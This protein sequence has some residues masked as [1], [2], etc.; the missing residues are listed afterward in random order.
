VILATPNAC[1][2]CHTDKTATWARD[3]IKGW[4]PSPKPGAQDFAEAFDLGDRGAPGAQAALLRIAKTETGSA[5]ARASAI[6]RLGRYPSPEALALAAQSLKSDD[7]AVQSAAITVIAGADPATRKTLLVPLLHNTS[8]LV[9]MNAARALAEVP[10]QDLSADDR[11]ALERVLDEYVAA[12][13]FNAERP[14]SHA[15][16]GALYRERGKTSDAR[17]AFETALALD[18]TF[19]AAAIS[20]AD[21]VRAEGDETAAEKILRQ[22]LAASPDSGAIQHALGLSLIRQ[23]RTADAM[24]WLSKAAEAAPDDP[25]FSYVLAVAL[26]DTGKQGEAIGALKNALARH[27]YD[28]D[29][30][31]A[32]ASYEVE[33]QAYSSALQRAELLNELE[34]GRADVVR[35]LA[36]LKRPAR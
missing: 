24:A 13:L 25:R 29:I 31:W 17:K 36:A 9:R 32:L 19:Y 8:R 3:A 12:Q 22:A 28:R 15:S 5:I 34:P 4:Y 35:L 33:T 11:T 23:K 1:N 26:H 27:P 18:P 10:A 30:L 20:L 21:L 2:Q 14:E 7:P 6:A 16:L